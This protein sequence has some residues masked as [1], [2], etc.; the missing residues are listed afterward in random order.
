[1]KI[2][3]I[4]ATGNV[5]SRLLA[6]LTRRHHTVTAIVRQPERVQAQPGVTA[7]KGDV[8]DPQGL[9]DVLKGHDA[10]ISSLQFTASDPRKLLEAVRASGVN[11]Y[12]IVGG[13]G[14][15]E[16]AP[17]VRLVDTPNFPEAYKT[18]A[19][20]GAAFLDLL[21]GETGLDWTFL[22]PSA[23]FVAGERTGKFRLGQDQLLTNA[24]GSRISFEDFAIALVD[25]LEKPAHSR[26]RFTVGY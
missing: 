13:A 22:S 15:L 17:G 14:S 2:A 21:R 9:A 4:G 23:L 10:V 1:M 16:I 25:E 24:E 18:E 5:G 20:A 12:L 6:E 3:L 11:R 19:T 26:Q 8:S 7:K